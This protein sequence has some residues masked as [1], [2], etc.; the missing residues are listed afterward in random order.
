MASGL[1]EIVLAFGID[2]YLR[3]T[4]CW[5]SVNAKAKAT[6]VKEIRRY[7]MTAFNLARL[8]TKDSR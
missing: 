3:R 1:G 6:A 7:V 2:V 4:A 5:R 8:K